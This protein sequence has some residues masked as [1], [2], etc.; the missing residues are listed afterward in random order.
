MLSFTKL[1]HEFTT[2]IHW[3]SVIAAYPKYAK[4]I[5]SILKASRKLCIESIHGMTHGQDDF[6]GRNIE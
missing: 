5:R 6:A 1:A 3:L 2:S 4:C